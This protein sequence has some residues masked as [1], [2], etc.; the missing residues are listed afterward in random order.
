MIEYTYYGDL[1][2]IG[3]YY[4]LN[5]DVARDKLSGFYN[6]AFHYFKQLC[7]DRRARVEMYSD[8]I[9]ITGDDVFD[10]LEIMNDLYIDCLKDGLFL[11]GAVVKGKLRYESRFTIDDF[12]KRLPVED[13]LARAVGLEKLYKGSRLIV[14]NELARDIFS[15]RPEW[16]THEGYYKNPRCNSREEEILRKVCP[17]PDNEHYE[18]LYY[19]SLQPGAQWSKEEFEFIKNYLKKVM[20]MYSDELKLHYRETIELIRRCEHRYNDLGISAS[21][22]G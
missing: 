9:V 5:K 8:S 13:M 18:M 19:W 14:E 16:L 3:K 1:L 4:R 22:T 2:G 15:N 6:N 20:V 7:Y 12:D 21:R 10:A 11:R 17:T